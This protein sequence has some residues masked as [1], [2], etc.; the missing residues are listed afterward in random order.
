MC[1]PKYSIKLNREKEIHFWDWNRRKG[2]RWYSNQ[3]PRNREG[4]QQVLGEITPCYA[5]LDEKDIREIKYL[6]PN[7]RLI[8]IAR[9]LIERAWSALLMEL[10]NSILGLDA[11]VFA[12]KNDE[13]LSPKELQRIERDS[14]PDRYDDQ[15][16]MDRLMHSTHSSRSNYAKSLRLWL[17][18]F[19]KDQLLILD[20]NDLSKKPR[21]LLKE[22]CR[23]I[24]LGKSDVYDKIKDSVL[25]ERVNAA[26]GKT[27]YSI[28]DSL[29][30]KMISYL[31]PFAQDFNQLLSELG[32][33][34][35]LCDYS[36]RSIDQKII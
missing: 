28:R 34:W 8:F 3:F 19:S 17:K 13:S 21:D 36:S 33:D 24:G 12:K 23:H 29:R 5:V 2:L 10:R 7:V 1:H 4:E 18:H 22:V 6:F 14:N 9:D 27:R 11:G 30:Q 16:F 26:T 20:Y 35:R 25:S 32:Y 15:Y 31:K